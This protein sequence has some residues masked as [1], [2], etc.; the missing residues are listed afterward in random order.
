MYG[1]LFTAVG[2]LVQLGVVE[3]SSDADNTALA[4]LRAS[5]RWGSDPRFCSVLDARTCALRSDC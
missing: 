1:G 5:S 4:W 2:L 3:R